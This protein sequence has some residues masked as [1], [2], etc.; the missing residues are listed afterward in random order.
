MRDGCAGITGHPKAQLMPGSLAPVPRA[1]PSRGFRSH[2]GAPAYFNASYSPGVVWVG[3]SG[4]WEPPGG[5]EAR[6]SRLWLR[7]CRS[8]CG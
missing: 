2:S 4:K 5:S 7:A 6:D 3:D 8:A 1:R